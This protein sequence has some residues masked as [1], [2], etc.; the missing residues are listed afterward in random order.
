MVTKGDSWGG[1]GGG[2]AHCLKVAA[3]VY[4]LDKHAVVH[5]LRTCFQNS[6]RRV[7]IRSSNLLSLPRFVI[8]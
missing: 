8:S 6:V 1:G 3:P 2:F 5:S 7:I 4:S